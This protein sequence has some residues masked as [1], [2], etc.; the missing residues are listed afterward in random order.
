MIAILIVIAPI[1]LFIRMMKFGRLTAADLPA[2]TPSDIQ[3]MRKASRIAF[4]ILP[5]LFLVWLLGVMIFSMNSR[6]NPSPEQM[7]T[8]TNIFFGSQFV[9]ILISAV[10]D[11]KAQRIKKRCLAKQPT[12]NPDDT[13]PAT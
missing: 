2:A 13:R 3:E 6:G 5:G 8:S 10:F 11:T 9:G 7:A 1:I 12:K 4:F